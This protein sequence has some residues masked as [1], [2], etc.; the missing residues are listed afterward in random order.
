MKHV[1]LD[2]S[3]LGLITQPPGVAEADAC[4]KWL[5]QK[6]NDGL[7]IVVPEIIDYELRRELLR[8]NK[9]S[10]VRRLDA[11]IS[12]PAVT[13]LPLTTP[14]M[15]TASQ[16]WATTRQEGKPTA[17]PHALDCDVILCGQILSHGQAADFVVATSNAKHFARYVV[18]RL[19]QEI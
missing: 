14:A 13:Y 5:V 18:A 3:P 19:W 4:R 11:F 16:L 7:S 6:Q 2:S 10:S 9:A 15:R 12:D 17:D 8:S 1:V